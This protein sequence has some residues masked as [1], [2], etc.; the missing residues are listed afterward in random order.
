MTHYTIFIGSGGGAKAASSFATVSSGTATFDI[1]TG[2]NAIHIQAAVGGGGG[3]IRG[4]DYDKAGAESQGPGGGSGAF[5]SDKIFTV[6]AGETMTYVVG[7]GGAAGNSGNQF[8]ISASGGTS[9]TLSGSSTGALFTLGGGGG[10]SGLNGGVKGPP[11]TNSAG[12]AGTASGIATAI[13]SGSFVETDNT[14]QNVTSN[15]SGPVGTFNQSSNGSVGD[16]TG[17][18][19]CGGDNCRI[20]GADGADSYS[21]GGAVAGGAGGS[22]SG[23][24]TNGAAGTRGSGGGGG[25]AQT[26]IGRTLGGDGGAGEI[27]YRFLNIF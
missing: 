7:A 3:S 15:T 4:A 13:T 24:G 2:Y 6:A 26:N 25:A 23:S 1:P 21:G 18:G 11:R 22:S 8:N 10:S 19:N 12:T 14:V 16:I 17:N 5:I 20:D 9:T 27:K